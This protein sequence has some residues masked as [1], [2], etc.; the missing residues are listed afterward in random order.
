M[1]NPK[2]T[3]PDIPQYDRHII[4]AETAARA[5]REGDKFRHLEHGNTTDEELP[6]IR[7]GY[8]M[9]Q[10]GLI[11]N[12]AIEPEMYFNEPGDNAAQKGA[13]DVERVH[14]LQELSEE[15]DGQLTSGHDYRHKG[16]GMI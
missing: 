3:S 12:Y 4:P 6:H 8:T 5:E 16:P 10:D 11:N 15:E 13:Q 7:D 14:E 2:S 1:S 9:D